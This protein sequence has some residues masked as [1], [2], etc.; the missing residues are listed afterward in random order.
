MHLDK[1]KKKN[2]EIDKTK[3]N[4]QF[5]RKFFGCNSILVNFLKHILDIFFCLPRSI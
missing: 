1:N 5:L 2:A 3:E 4:L